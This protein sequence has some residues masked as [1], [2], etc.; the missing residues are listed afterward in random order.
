M[1]VDVLV[2]G[3]GVAG[4]AAAIEAA[5]LGA[6]VLV[7]EK[8]GFL[9]GV[10][11]TS[12]G[13][14]HG[15]NSVVMRQRT[16]SIF[17]GDTADTFAEELIDLS[18][19]LPVTNT[20]REPLLRA[21]A[22]LST[23]TID[24]LITMGIQFPAGTNELGLTGNPSRAW[25][26]TPFA[27]ALTPTGSGREMMA[28]MI[29]YAGAQGVEFMIDTRAV[30]LRGGASG[31]T[32]VNAVDITGAAV[33]INAGSVILATGG[34]H[35]NDV[36]LRA[37]HPNAS[38]LG[39]DHIRRWNLP[40]AEGQGLTMAETI[41]AGILDLPTPIAG[42]T[43]NPAWGIWVTPEGDR[44]FDESWQYG[45]ASAAELGRLGFYYHWTIMNDADRP[46]G[47]VAGAN[48]FTGTDLADLV[49][50]M[51]AAYGAEF[52]ANLQAAIDAYN[53]ALE[54][55]DPVPFASPLGIDGVFAPGAATPA[56]PR[57]VAIDDAGVLW[58]QRSGVF[59]DIWGTNSGLSINQSGQV[60]TGG[61]GVIPGLFAAGE[62]VGWILPVQYGGSGMAIT[63]WTNQARITGRAAAQ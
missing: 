60:L 44:F 19:D 31:V 12:G 14:I 1:T 29:A 57:H 26:G 36:L 33:T 9:G 40:G 38:D 10:T 51:P 47:L 35:N 22:D 25:R 53:D 48:V 39:A 7:I 50:N 37:H 27:R 42:L 41:G 32:G 54:A 55:G 6:D 13:M 52:L 8:L 62:V 2:V 43:G 16:G 11:A 20:V 63:I 58:A 23:D 59:G 49:D 17:Q 34:F 4:L 46:A 18:L 61:G 3:S 30:T 56:R 24:W 28:R 5:Y 21:I 15:A 45:I